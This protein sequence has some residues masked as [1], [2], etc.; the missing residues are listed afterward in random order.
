MKLGTI[1]RQDFNQKRGD[2]S[3]NDYTIGIFQSIGFKEFHKYLL[4]DAEKQEASEGQ[5]AF[6]EGKEQMMAAT[7]RYARKQTKWIAQ[8]FMRS[9][10][11]CPPIYA[12]DSTDPSLWENAAQKP[13][14]KVVQAYLDGD[15]AGISHL[16]LSVDPATAYSFQDT[17]QMLT[18]DVCGVSLKGQLQYKAHV[19]GRKHQHVLRKSKMR[20]RLSL[21]DDVDLEARKVQLEAVLRDHL[22]DP[23]INIVIDSPR[24]DQIH[25][26]FPAK[27]DSVALKEKITTSCSWIR[28]VEVDYFLSEKPKDTQKSPP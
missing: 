14:F 4:L 12:V 7:R 2:T 27:D 24:N 18:C 25:L 5:K 28:D 3:A 10:R 19:Q 6:L 16:A 23:S 9:D 8:R 17:R 13:A 22:T 1:F 21:H 11:Q 26:V 15:L 20:L